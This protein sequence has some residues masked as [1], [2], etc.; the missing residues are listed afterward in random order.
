M[1]VPILLSLPVCKVSPNILI[2]KDR[3]AYVGWVCR[4]P[5]LD[6]G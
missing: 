4:A 5:G 3:E 2:R 6:E 1:N